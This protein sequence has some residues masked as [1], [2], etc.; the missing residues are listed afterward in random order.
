MSYLLTHSLLSSWLYAMREDPYEDVTSKRDT[1][2][3][4]LTVLRREPTEVTEAMQK[5]IEFENLITDV[6]N[7]VDVSSSKWAEPVMKAADTLRGSLLQY[8]ARRNIEIAGIPFVLYGRADALKQGV[9][10]DTKFS[11]GY[12]RGK[13][14][15]STQ[16][17]MYFE[18]IP[19]AEA[20]VY[21]ISNGTELWTEVYRREESPSII[22]IIKDFVS[23]LMAVNLF[24]IY[25]EKWESKK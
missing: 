3:D 21:L 23:W 18:I 5:G 8:K 17:P 24:D 22:P 12:D 25:I 19:E 14:I 15:D 2:A 4:F 10:Y 7:G 1:Y 13:Y 11:S 16:H 20:F 6:I 9:I